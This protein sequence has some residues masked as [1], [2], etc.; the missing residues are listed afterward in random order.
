MLPRC[1]ASSEL[2]SALEKMSEF[3]VL[4]QLADIENQVECEVALIEQKIRELAQ[5]KEVFSLKLRSIQEDVALL[6]T[7]MRRQNTLEQT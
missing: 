2:I 6:K 7:G 5:E 1:V 4:S 3:K